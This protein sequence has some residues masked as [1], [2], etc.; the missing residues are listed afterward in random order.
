MI[1]ISEL[2]G[3]PAD[4]HFWSLKCPIVNQTFHHTKAIAKFQHMI[5]TAILPQKL[6]EC[7]SHLNS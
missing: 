6:F 3:H 1:C 4:I 5:F 7:L 2:R